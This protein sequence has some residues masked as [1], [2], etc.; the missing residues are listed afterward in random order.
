M[1]Q[2]AGRWQALTLR[3]GVNNQAGKAI[4]QVL[5]D[6][7]QQYFRQYHG[8]SHLLDCFRHLDEIKPQLVQPE[9]VEYGLWFHDIVCVP[10]ATSN[11]IL[12]AAAARYAAAELGLPAQFSRQAVQLILLTA[13]RRPAGDRDGA[14]LAD[15][16]LAVL[17]RDWPGFLAYERQIRAEYSYLP[18]A[19]YC[20]GRQQVI[21]QLLQRDAIYQTQ[22][23]RER[24]E[25]A[26][27]GNLV[28][29][30]EQLIIS[31]R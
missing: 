23:F 18:A 30:S 19:A 9:L 14:Y 2:L 21:K 7:Y 10:G 27:Q 20:Q 16:D 28:A 3:L 25:Q 31:S 6:S 11:E 29:L 26:A 24:Y 1:A 12:S 13:H 8:S 17:G 15:I 22:Y 5:L 4:L